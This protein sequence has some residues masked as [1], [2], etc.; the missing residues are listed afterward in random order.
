[1]AS[2]LG[3]DPAAT[4]ALKRDM[5]L[6]FRQLLIVA[7]EATT[8]CGCCDSDTSHQEMIRTMLRIAPSEGWPRPE[9]VPARLRELRHTVIM[10]TI[11]VIDRGPL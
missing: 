10:E 5:E 9:D 4:L 11:A 6:R 8:T 1:M 3:E 7:L 2:D